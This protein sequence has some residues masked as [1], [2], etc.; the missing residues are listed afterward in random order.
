MLKRGCIK[1]I[2][3]FAP[4]KNEYNS[5]QQT[6]FLIKSECLINGLKKKI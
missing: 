1:K 4:L 3:S 6:T 5:S 2:K